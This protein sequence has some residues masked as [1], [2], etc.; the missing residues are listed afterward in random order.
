MHG[1]IPVQ[2]TTVS[3][4]WAFWTMWRFRTLRHMRSGQFWGP[5]VGDKLIIAFIV[6]TVFWGY[7]ERPRTLAH[8][9]T[10]SVSVAKLY[11]LDSLDVHL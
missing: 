6:M 3:F 2:S 4:F 7:G 8:S 1:V 11:C 5:R 10:C 9:A